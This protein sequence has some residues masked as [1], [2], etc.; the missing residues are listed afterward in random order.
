[1]STQP[2]RLLHWTPR[3][4]GV[5]YAVFISAFALD[6]WGMDGSF[7]DK[8][9]G[10]LIHLTPT[11]AVV[12][13]LIIAWIRPAAGGVIFIGLAAVFSLFFGWQ[14]ATVLL[15]MALPLIVIGLLFLADSWAGQTRLRARPGA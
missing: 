10:F 1:M 8:L 7:G 6:V 4:L 12:V 13:A 5:L 3:L 14:E 9:G 11:Y 15:I 2:N